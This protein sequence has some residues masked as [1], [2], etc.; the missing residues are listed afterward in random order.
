MQKLLYMKS[1]LWH[2]VMHWPL[3]ESCNRNLKILI[4]KLISRLDR[5]LEYFLWN[6]PQVNAI[7]LPWW[8]VNTGSC[9][10]LVLS[11]T[12]PLPEL[13]FT[14]SSLMANGIT[15]AEWFHPKAYRQFSNISRTQSQNINV[16]RLVLQ[17]SLS[18]P[19]KP[20]VKLRMKM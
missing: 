20:G 1:K 6:Y 17:S 14:T 11:S 8:L 7:T 13:M 9:N 16:S 5:Y 12:K 10:G 2:V 18:N 3:P 4:F 19:W 15:R